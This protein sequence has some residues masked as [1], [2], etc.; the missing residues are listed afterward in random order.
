[1]S[2][3]G[4]IAKAINIFELSVFF[5]AVETR[6]SIAFIIIIISCDK[7]GVFFFSTYNEMVRN[8]LIYV[9]QLV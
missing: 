3:L 4:D 5:S 6:A 9:V 2:P 7:N 1:M 8:I